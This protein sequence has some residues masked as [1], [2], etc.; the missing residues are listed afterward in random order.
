M[1]PQDLTGFLWRMKCR[2]E[3][4]HWDASKHC[5]TGFVDF[6][7]GALEEVLA[8]SALVVM[9]VNLRIRC[10]LPMAY[11][12]THGLTGEQLSRILIDVIKSMWEVGCRVLGCVTDSD[13]KNR[14][15]AKTLGIA[16]DGEMIKNS[17]PHPCCNGES[18]YWIFDTC[19][20]LKLAR[21]SI[22]EY[23]V[24]HSTDNGDDR[25]I[26]WNYFLQLFKLQESDTLFLANKISGDHINYAT[27]K[28]KV[29]LAA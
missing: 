17:F 5:F 29:S 10:K 7:G 11:Y 3:K 23:K 19:H 18:V 2:S 24:L 6:G 21:N 26:R 9:A 12:F 20:L 4:S 8:T 25:V 22:G 28:M 16:I 27:K 15:A 1:I 14:A 13:W